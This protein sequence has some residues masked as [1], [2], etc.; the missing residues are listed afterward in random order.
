M[1]KAV[2]VKY[3]HTVPYSHMGLYVAF[4]VT[5]FTELTTNGVYVYAERTYLTADGIIPKLRKRVLVSYDP[6]TAPCENAEKLVFEHSEVYV[7]AVYRNVAKLM[8][9]HKRSVGKYVLV[10]LSLGTHI[11][12]QDK[13]LE[14]YRSAY[15][16]G[17]AVKLGFGFCRK[18]VY[19]DE[20]NFAKQGKRGMKLIYRYS[21][22]VCTA[23]NYVGGKARKSGLYILW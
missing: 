9:Y 21:A 14:S 3:G 5:C 20:R 16:V 12:S 1:G 7:L 22:E 4:A 13:L 2:L 18:V 19:I 23:Q 6:A 8:V 17:D 11:Y 15:N 10:L